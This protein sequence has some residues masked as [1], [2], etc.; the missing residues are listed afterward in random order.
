[1]N[2]LQKKDFDLLHCT[3]KHSPLPVDREVWVTSSRRS[4]RGRVVVIA[5]TPRND[6]IN[7]PSETIKKNQ[8]HFQR[9]PECDDPV[10]SSSKPEPTE[11]INSS[12]PPNNAEL[13]EDDGSSPLSNSIANSLTWPRVQT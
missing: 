7:T 3:Q 6:L 8:Q 11:D 1:M 2:N 4:V 5:D 13:T 9:L 10:V 12:L